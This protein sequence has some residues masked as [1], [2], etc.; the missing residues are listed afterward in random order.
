MEVIKINKEEMKMEA[1]K[2]FG[3]VMVTGNK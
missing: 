1:E 2:K 3:I